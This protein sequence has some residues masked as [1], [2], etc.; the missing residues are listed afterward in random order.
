[1]KIKV[2]LLSLFLAVVSVTSAQSS[3]YVRQVRKIKNFKSLNVS[4]V[5]DVIVIPSKNYKVTVE[6]TTK[7][8]G[9]IKT[10]LEGDALHIYNDRI[11]SENFKGNKQIH[12][13]VFVEMP[14]INKVNLSGAGDITL[15]EGFSSINFKAKVSGSG[16]LKIPALNTVLFILNVSGSGDAYIGG[17][18]KNLE[19]EI[20]GS[21]DVK[22]KNLNS[23]KTLQYVPEISAVAPYD[24]SKVATNPS[25]F[26][27]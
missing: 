11:S 21:G 23:G 6:S 20:R 7:C 4:G 10:K 25:R 13:K 26:V 9:K 22:T 8:I 27:P 5:V 15:K 2:I 14:E 18:I 3:K 1:M 17:N 24:K 12:M 16:D 19:C